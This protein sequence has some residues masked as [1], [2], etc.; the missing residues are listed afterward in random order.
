MG[1]TLYELATLH[2]PAGEVGDAQQFFHRTRFHCKSL[3]HWIPNIPIDFQTI[4]LKAIAEFPHERGDE[5]A[6][7][8]YHMATIAPALAAVAQ[9]PH[10]TV[11]MIEGVCVGGGLEIACHCDLRIAAEHGR[12][13]KDVHTLAIRAFAD[14]IQ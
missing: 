2:H 5:A 1:I 13:V 8:H 12:P 7:R 11:A 10:P 3:R 6:V 14:R 4:L 9:C